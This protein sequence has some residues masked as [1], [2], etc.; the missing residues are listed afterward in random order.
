MYRRPSGGTEKSHRALVTVTSGS[1]RATQRERRTRSAPSRSPCLLWPGGKA[2][3]FEWKGSANAGILS[4]FNRKH[5]SYF[6]CEAGTCRNYFSGNTDHKNYQMNK[7]FCLCPAPFIFPSNA[8]YYLHLPESPKPLK[9]VHSY[10]VIA[11][12]FLCDLGFSG[13]K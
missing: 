12:F 4:F 2:A 7:H 1:H 9:S 8:L 10:S 11:S 6:H 5:S 3:A 13:L